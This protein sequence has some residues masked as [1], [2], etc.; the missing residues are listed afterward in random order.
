MNEYKHK[1]IVVDWYEGR[2]H[3]IYTFRD[4]LYNSYD[5][6]W[7]R[8]GQGYYHGSGCWG[9]PGDEV[10]GTEGLPGSIKTLDDL[11]KHYDLVQAT[12]V[13]CKICEGCMAEDSPCEHLVWDDE[14]GCWGGPGSTE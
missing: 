10:G 4:G 5:I 3:E 11:V 12:T 8:A 6:D 9:G 7:D 14:I 1:I 2:P 13:Y